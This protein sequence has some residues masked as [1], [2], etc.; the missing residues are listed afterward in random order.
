VGTEARDR[1]LLSRSLLPK[2]GLEDE[3]KSSPVLGLRKP[4]EVL[5]RILSFRSR[6][7]LF[8]PFLLRVVSAKLLLLLFPIPSTNIPNFSPIKIS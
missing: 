3:E 7:A 2:I 4:W 1:G 6:F 8:R 5:E